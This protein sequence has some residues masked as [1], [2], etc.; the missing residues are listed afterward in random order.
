MKKEDLGDRVRNW[1]NSYVNHCPPWSSI[2]G[3]IVREIKSE[4]QK[5][6]KARKKVIAK[7]IKVDFYTKDK[8]RFTFKGY[9]TKN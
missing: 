6:V 2:L 1:V 3:F 4:K 7:P 5:W 9:K 8:K